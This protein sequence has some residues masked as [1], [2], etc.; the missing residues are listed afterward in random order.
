MIDKIDINS[1]PELPGK[2][3]TKQPESNDTTSSTADASLE[4]NYESLIQKAMESPESDATQVEKA[5]ELIASGELESIDN[6]REAAKDIIE[7]G[8]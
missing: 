2:P 4:V 6:I 8:I 1:I 3:A 5:K 7:F